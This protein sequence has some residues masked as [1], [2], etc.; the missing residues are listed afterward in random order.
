[1]FS[2]QPSCM[3][4]TAHLIDAAKG[5]KGRKRGGEKKNTRLSVHL[6]AELLSEQLVRPRDSGLFDDVNLMQG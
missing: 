4:M 1:M 3:Q 2:F 5:E 6:T